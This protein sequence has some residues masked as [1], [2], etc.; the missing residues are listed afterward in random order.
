[1]TRKSASLMAS[2]LLSRITA[3]QARSDLEHSRSY[4]LDR[5]VNI[6]GYI[7]ELTQYFVITDYLQRKGCI[8]SAHH[9][10]RFLI[11]GIV[12]TLRSH[13]IARWSK[14]SQFRRLQTEPNAG[15]TSALANEISDWHSVIIKLFSRMPDDCI[16]NAGDRLR[17]YRSLAKV[18]CLSREKS[19]E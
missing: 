9:R 15:P 18:G 2:N 17:K 11:F 8:P 16:S 1:M 4:V 7:E 12:N 3:V 14:R 6:L 19:C 10:N 13:L 5:L